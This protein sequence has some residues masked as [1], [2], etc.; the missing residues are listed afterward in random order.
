MENRARR[1][2]VTAKDEHAW[3]EYCKSA[4]LTPLTLKVS[5]GPN[6]LTSLSNV[7]GTPVL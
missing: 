7:F 4:A 1:G 3:H 5:I 6:Y 2:P